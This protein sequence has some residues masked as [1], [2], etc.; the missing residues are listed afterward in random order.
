MPGMLASQLR[1]MR[2]ARVLQAYLDGEVEPPTAR[3]VAE[4][5]EEC[6]RCGLAAD[7]YA[8][9]KTAIAACD[10]VRPQVEPATVQRLTAFARGLADEDVDPR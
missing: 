7:T 3:A 6:R 9:I 1:C 2:V 10:D 8:A 4:H 5:L